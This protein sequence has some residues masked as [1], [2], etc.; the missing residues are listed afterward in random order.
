M[1]TPQQGRPRALG[2][3]PYF[4]W[5]NWCYVTWDFLGLVPRG[6][7]LV[8]CYKGLSCLKGLSWY[9]ATRDFLASRDFLGTVPQGTF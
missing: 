5:L 3:A 7:F 4:V 9:G 6:T 8:R 2:S 1:V